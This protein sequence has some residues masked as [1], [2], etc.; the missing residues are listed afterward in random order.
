MTAV[1]IT[2]IVEQV[3]SEALQKKLERITILDYLTG[4]GLE[5]LKE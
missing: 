5:I 2:T 1:F 4:P 3:N